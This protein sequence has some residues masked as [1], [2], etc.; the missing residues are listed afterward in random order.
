ML[1]AAA[2]ARPALR[3]R[4]EVEL[5]AFSTRDDAAAA[6]AALASGGA[7][8]LGVSC[9][10]W[11]AVFAR[12]LAEA[13]KAAR[14]A[15]RVLFGGPEPSSRPLPWLGAHPA[16]DWLAVGE[17]EDTFCEL[18]EALADGRD[19]AGL[20]GLAW[21]EGG[22][23]RLGP[24]R[25]PRA[26]LDGLP[27]PYESGVLPLP[28]HP[29]VCFE[30]SRGCPFDCKYCDW[31]N[32]QRVRRYGEGRAERDMAL[33]LRRLPEARVFV[34]DSDL[35]L[36]P[37]RGARLAR[38]WRR[39]AGDSPCAFEV[40]TYLPRLDDDA[41]RSLDAP[42]FT[43]CVGLQSSNPKALAAVSRF[44]DAE[45]IRERAAAFRRLAPR[46]RLNL[47]LIYGLPGDD[48][49][50]FAGSLEFAL[51]LE[52]DTLMLF[53]ALALPG[54]EMGRDPAAF[55]LRAQA[56]PPYRVLGTDGFPE[57]ALAEADQLAFQLFT[58]QRHPACFGVLRRLGTALAP[59]VPGGRLGAFTGFA[60]HIAGTP[61]ALAPV[62]ERARR[63]LLGFL[64][65]QEEPWGAM[66]AAERDAGLAR[67]L[68]DYARRRLEEAGAGA[69]WPGLAAVLAAERREA[70]WRE[71]TAGAGFH[72]LFAALAG[73]GGGERLW[74]GTERAA[75][76]EARFWP[77]AERW[78]WLAP[79]PE[80]DEPCRGGRHFT[81][82]DLDPAPFAAGTL[83]GVV[84]SQVCRRLA[85]G[86]RRGLFAALRRRARPGARLAVFDALEAGGPLD[87]RG[88]CEE[89]RAAGWRLPR[90]GRLLGGGRWCVLTAV[91][92][93]A[94][95]GGGPVGAAGLY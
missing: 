46:A 15:G 91:T 59:R 56:E 3:G 32:K 58:F 21:R 88:L 43:V 61:F 76:A 47:Q 74:V 60:R 93:G 75:A 92:A 45:R 84:L 22:E 68:G 53:P 12:R 36:D 13:Y 34:A 71:L 50:G 25:L 89:L 83:R 24:A 23:C 73:D 35:F 54:S 33:L 65:F 63:D 19:P 10:L 28:G 16:V 79:G 95:G 6:G 8:L 29:H 80:P 62:H 78:H 82:A 86:R 55:G 72:R 1:K 39:A 94:D 42:Q 9:Y 49:Q 64:T 7:D 67:L 87:V 44:F 41:L 14:P 77:G 40:H 38:A 37:G 69:D 4:A 51:S 18:L 5:H 2:E 17:A 57:A 90:E 31:Q 81:E 20:A 85:P 66:A 70:L 27:S 52:P 48:P 26:D 11:N 30:A